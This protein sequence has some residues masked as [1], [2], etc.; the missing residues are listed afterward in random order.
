MIACPSLNSLLNQ[1]PSQSARD[2]KN[3]TF[4]LDTHNRV[5]RHGS[6][7]WQPIG[8]KK[9][10]SVTLAL[11]RGHA[12]V[13]PPWT[14]SASRPCTSGA[15]AQARTCA[16]T[17]GCPRT[18][19]SSQAAMRARASGEDGGSR[20]PERGSR[21]RRLQGREGNGR[22]VVGIS[23]RQVRKS[24]QDCQLHAVWCFTH[25]SPLGHRLEVHVAERLRS[26]SQ[27][28]APARAAKLEAPPVALV[29]KNRPA[30]ARWLVPVAAPE[31]GAAARSS[32]QARG[33]GPAP[34]ARSRSGPR[35][36]RPR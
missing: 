1:A 21:W 27:D 22:R 14:A 28:P 20:A 10:V 11:Q 26:T 3:F 24:S 23:P 4:G 35:S 16:V 13:L 25:W 9:I 30:A 18:L 17:S 36:A 33:G 7:F 29:R 8:A 15:A 12:V 2:T 31:V 32:R 5:V 6:W 34:P 19:S